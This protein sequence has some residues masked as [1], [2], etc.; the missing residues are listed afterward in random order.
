MNERIMKLAGFD[1]PKNLR[2]LEEG[3]ISGG[4]VHYQL[5]RSPKMSSGVNSRYYLLLEGLPHRKDLSQAL[6]ELIDE[7]IGANVIYWIVPVSNRAKFGM[8]KIVPA[9][10]PNYLDRTISDSD[11]DKPLLV[12]EVKLEFPENTY[13]DAKL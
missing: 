5:L 11:L 3:S 9:E 7:H 4:D 10:L 6:K 1:I 8:D 12:A 2:V 13:G